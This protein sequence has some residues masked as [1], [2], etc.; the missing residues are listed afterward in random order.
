MTAGRL[1]A[2]T[3]TAACLKR[4]AALDQNGPALRSILQVN[5][6]AQDLA[7]ALD[8]ER[9]QGTLRGPMHG[10]PVVIKDCIATGDK[11]PTTMGS[12][13]LA[14]VR[15]SRDAA[16]VARLRAAGAVVL[17]KSNLTEWC[18]ARSFNSIA[19]WSAVGG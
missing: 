6:D 8:R 12:L 7:G 9:R 10:V 4:V 13:A 17:G 11:M 3:L 1:I 18:N 5:P 19:G 16:L 15:S 2:A 14:G